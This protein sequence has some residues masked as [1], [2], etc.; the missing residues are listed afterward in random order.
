MM[1][2]DEQFLPPTCKLIKVEF[3]PKLAPTTVMTAPLVDPDV[4]ENTCGS[5]YKQFSVL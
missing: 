1:D 4:M 2:S 3:V 5:V